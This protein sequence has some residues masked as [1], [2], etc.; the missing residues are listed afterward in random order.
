MDEGL[1]LYGSNKIFEKLKKM[2]ETNCIPQKLAD[3]EKA[4][5]AGRA[6][7]E[8]YLQNCSDSLPAAEYM[9]LFCTNE[10]REEFE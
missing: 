4:A 3:L 2:L 9:K 6:E 8:T 1:F 7:A 10:E 5:T